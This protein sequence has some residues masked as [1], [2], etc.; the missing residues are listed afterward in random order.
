[1]QYIG[2]EANRWEE[3]FYLGYDPETQIEYGTDEESAKLVHVRLC[4]A[5]KSYGQRELA[6][7]AGVAREQL[8]AILKREA[9]PRAKTIAK[10]LRAISALAVPVGGA[11]ANVLN[12]RPR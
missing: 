6:R 1:M 4:E 10:L 7:T 5:A 8:R 11:S 2:K 3:Q 9:R 12:R